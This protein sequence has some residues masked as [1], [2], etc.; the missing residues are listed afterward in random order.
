MIRDVRF[1]PLVACAVAALAGLKLIG[2]VSGDPSALSGARLAIAQDQQT[3]EEAVQPPDAETTA[4]EDDTAAE[5]AAMDNPEIIFEDGTAP[6]E[7]AERLL[8][9]RLGERRQLLEERERELDLRENLLQAAE[10]RIEERLT[11]LR[12]IEER[13]NAAEDTQRAK[14]DERLANLITIYEAMK[15]KDAAEVFNRLDLPVLVE[16]ASRIN[17][18]TMAEIL[19]A[20]TP[21]R[22]EQLTVALA[23]FAQQVP[24]LEQALPEIIGTEPNS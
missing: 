3:Q 5:T 8:L 15:P 19:A 13:L 14:V 24:T 23:S 7:Q 1:L 10:E 22:A 20:M 2:L 17:A 12:A 6:D 11:E 18:R 16:V 21:E 4:S 9:E